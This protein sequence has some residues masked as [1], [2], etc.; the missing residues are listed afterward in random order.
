MEYISDIC[1]L[2]FEAESNNYYF[3]NQTLELFVSIIVI[4]AILS[5]RQTI[6]INNPNAAKIS[7]KKTSK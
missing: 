4:E 1:E 3:K 6:N 2:T 7:T 5:S